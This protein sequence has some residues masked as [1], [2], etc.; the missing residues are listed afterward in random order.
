MLCGKFIFIVISGVF[1]GKLLGVFFVMVKFIFCRFFMFLLLG[2]CYVL[3]GNIDMMSMV[4]SEGKKMG[5][6]IVVVI[7]EFI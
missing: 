3:F 7:L 6:E 5:D 2:F 1:Y 4:F